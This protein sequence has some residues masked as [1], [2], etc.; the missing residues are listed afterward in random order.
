MQPTEGYGQTAIRTFFKVFSG[1]V[2]FFIAIF[3]SFFVMAIIFGSLG[4]ADEVV[5][6]E[7][8]VIAGQE[9]GSLRFVS[10]PI[11]GVILGERSSDDFMYY[12]ADFAVTYGYEVK[13]QLLD[14][15][16]DETVDGIILEIHSPGG[17]I[18]G[19]KA[20]TSGIAQYKEKTGKPV[21]VYI[22]SIAAS[23]GYWV[24][25]SGDSVVADYGVSVGSIGV[26]SGPF[27]Y[28]QSVVSEDGGAFVGGIVT[29]NGIATTYISAGSSKDFGNPY[30]EMTEQE[31]SI[32]QRSVSVAYDDFVTYV[33]D[34]RQLARPVITESIGAMIY[35][36]TQ[37]KAFGLID[38]TGDKQFAYEKLAT[39]VAPGSSFSIER[40]YQEQGFF[41]LLFSAIQLYSPNKRVSSQACL[42]S[43]SVLAYHGDI[44]SLCR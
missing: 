20:I 32:M 10:I 41:E 27:K 22:G 40:L 37:A 21:H 30:R 28:Y 43:A 33:S 26:I 9:D 14:L 29:E 25:A 13:E 8:E 24:A 34:Q 6:S 3:G 23:G 44:S 17:T 31:M 5:E 11:E 35:D 19:T 39:A 1:V 16:E 7:Y 15:A 42:S 4:S 36:E 38:A 18:F 12:L 2:A